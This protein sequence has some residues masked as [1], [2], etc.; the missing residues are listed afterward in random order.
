M[1]FLLLVNFSDQ[2]NPAIFTDDAGFHSICWCLGQVLIFTKHLPTLFPIK[3]FNSKNL[4]FKLD[5]S[6]SLKVE[7]EM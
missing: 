7:S 4:S 3:M 2:P 1:Y 6:F 5:L